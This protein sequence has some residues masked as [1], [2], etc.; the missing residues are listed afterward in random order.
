MAEKA[1][2]QLGGTQSATGDLKET[3]TR[4]AAAGKR[5]LRSVGA[6][7]ANSPPYTL[8]ILALS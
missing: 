4:V 1:S 5:R 3:A 8:D 7:I 6:S 2:L